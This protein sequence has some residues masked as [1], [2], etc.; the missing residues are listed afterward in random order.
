M[1]DRNSLIQVVDRIPVLQGAGIA[2]IGDRQCSTIRKSD[3]KSGF[4]TYVVFQEADLQP[5]SFSNLPA[6]SNTTP[7]PI[8]APTSG[9]IGSALLKAG[10]ECGGVVL[11]A[12]VTA[13]SVAALPV[14]GGFTSVPLAI[15]SSALLTASLSCGMSVGR[16]WNVGHDPDLNRI[17]DKSEWYSVVGN[18]IE[19]IDLADAAHTGLKTITK[20]RALRKATSSSMVE[21]LRGASRDD[22]KRIAEE[23]AIFTGEASSRRSFLRMVRQG[24]LPRL[25]EVKQIRE[26]VAKTLLDAATSG[27]TIA[28]SFLPGTQGRK[29]GLMNELI[30]HV[31]QEN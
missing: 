5:S 17:L 7:Q 23:M 14:S 1:I 27:T 22:R 2:Y 21:L 12:T 18:I 31:V 25:Y 3:H 4:R 8:G 24:R 16:L 11:S 15:A 9:S 13:A 28:E 26:E 29:P 10:I 6:R 20:Y 19:V 30:V